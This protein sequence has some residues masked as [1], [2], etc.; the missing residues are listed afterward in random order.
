MLIT[1]RICNLIVRFSEYDFY[2]KLLDDVI[3]LKITLSVIWT[4][5]YI[6]IYIYKSKL[7]ENPIRF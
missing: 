5:P 6:Y 3:L 1:Y 2:N 4:Q 7:R